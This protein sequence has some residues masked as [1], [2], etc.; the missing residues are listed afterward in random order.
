MKKLMN[1][2]R[3]E[4]YSFFKLIGLLIIQ[5]LGMT[6]RENQ[7]LNVPFKI[8]FLD[9]GECFFNVLGVFS[10]AIIWYSITPHKGASWT[11]I[12]NCFIGIWLIIESISYILYFY[13]S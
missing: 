11:F 5:T 3:K 6:Y 13:Y 12:L 10:A 7:T 1:L 9:M 8:I 4:I 2:H